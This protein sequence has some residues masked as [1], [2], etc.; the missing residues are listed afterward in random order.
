[1]R[2]EIEGLLR[3]LTLTG[4][5]FA[6][7]LGWSL[8]QLALGIAGFV[9]GLLTRVPNS[10]GGFFGGGQGLTWVVRHRLVTL[11]GIL[12]GLIEL[13]VVLAAAAFVR[14]RYATKAGS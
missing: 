12:F 14:Q 3:D 7:A 11:D 2:D 5:A 6:I 8:Y 13:A 4:I 10:E 1:M 9:D